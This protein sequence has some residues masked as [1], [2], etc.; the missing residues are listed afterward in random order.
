M[1]DLKEL[2]DTFIEC[3][4]VVDELI[5]VGERESNGEKISEEEQESIQGRLIMKFLKMQQLSEKM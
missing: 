5:K 1:E 2:R 3:A 4:N